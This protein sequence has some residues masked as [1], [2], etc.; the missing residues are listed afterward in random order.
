MC[1]GVF[2]ESTFRR[3]IFYAEVLTCSVHSNAHKV[4]VRM[5][6]SCQ[7]FFSVVGGTYII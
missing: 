7:F 2:R 1:T 3:N 5:S 6:T 4:I